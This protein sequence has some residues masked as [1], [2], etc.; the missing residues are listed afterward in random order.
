MRGVFAF[1]FRT[2]ELVA[3]TGAHTLGSKG[4]GDPDVFDNSYFK[5]LL[6]KPWKSGKFC[7]PM[8]DNIHTKKK[9]KTFVV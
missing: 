9:K 5:I 2:Q 1:G 3:L 7:C 8:S 6:Q 4:F